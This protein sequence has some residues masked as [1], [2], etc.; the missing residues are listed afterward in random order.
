MNYLSLEK[1]F[2]GLCFFIMLFLL[3]ISGLSTEAAVV[4]SQ[5]NLNSATL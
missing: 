2:R 3:L 5:G 1:G 4:Q